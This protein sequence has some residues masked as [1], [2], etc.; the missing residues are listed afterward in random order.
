LSAE[1]AS[2]R[3]GSWRA[4]HGLSGLTRA[5]AAAKNRGVMDSQRP[6]TPPLSELDA[7]TLCV[8]L[9]RALA[10]SGDIPAGYSALA[11][12]SARAREARSQ[13]EPWAGE[14][15]RLYRC[16]MDRYAECY[17]VARD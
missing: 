11:A 2:V 14:L 6:A 12:G 9:A 7:L 5:P 10:A 3:G 1:P 8:K 15:E 16:V 13:G 4:L 17:N